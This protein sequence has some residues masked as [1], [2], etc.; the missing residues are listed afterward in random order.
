MAAKQI[1]G[2]L[3]IKALKQMIEKGEIETVL[4][5]FPD[6]YGRLLGK[7][8]NGQFFVD[9]VLDGSLHVCDYL[10]ACDMEMDPVPGY[11]FTSW[12]DGYGD[13]RLVPDMRTLRLA[14]WLE[15]TALVLCDVANEEK[16]ELIEVAPRTI[17]Q[18]TSCSSRQTRL[19]SHGRI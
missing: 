1:P 13:V 9:D 8:I 6:I 10:L 18:K 14:S 19:H 7:R 2:M 12:A 16:D 3:N 5:V 4:A 11:A 17:L 15:K